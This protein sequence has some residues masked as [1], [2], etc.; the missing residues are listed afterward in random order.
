M[1]DRA[2]IAFT[3]VIPAYNPGRF[4]DEAL[5]SVASQTL[6][7]DWVVVVDD[8]SSDGTHE[9]ALGLL[10]RHR[11]PGT[12]IRQENQGISAARNAGLAARRTDWVALL[13]SDD[14]WLPDHLACLEHAILHCPDAVV[15]FGDSRF[16]GDSRS[17]TDLLASAAT[18][19]LSVETPAAD[20]H[21]LSE[22]VFD[23][24]LPGLFFPVSATSFR[25]DLGEPEPRFDVSLR[26][27]EDRFFFLQM[28]RRGRFVF[29]DRQISRTRRHSANTTNHVNSAR[30]HADVLTLL[31]RIEGFDLNDLQRG[32]VRRSATRAAEALVYA[33]SQQGLSAYL[34]GRRRAAAYVGPKRRVALRDFLRASAISLGLKRSGVPDRSD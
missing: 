17:R 31:A 11:L 12:V 13:D 30:L 14:L 33:S 10:E 16:F 21:I 19:K 6:L 25:M 27:G 9:N 29:I 3:I 15:A 18:R 4:L 2:R 23:E 5:E 22:L 28:A 1:V 34:A 7:P 8:G 20:V 24:L 26:S 32:A